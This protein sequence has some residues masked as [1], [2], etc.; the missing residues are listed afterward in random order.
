MRIG[1]STSCDN[2]DGAVCRFAFGE[3]S[4]TDRVEARCDVPAFQ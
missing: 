2:A 1:T 3:T 4:V